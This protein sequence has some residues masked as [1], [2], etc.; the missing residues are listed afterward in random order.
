MLLRRILLLLRG[1]AA[2]ETTTVKP[3]TGRTRSAVATKASTGPGATTVAPVATVPAKDPP[4][5]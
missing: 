5:H 2:S 3:T 1:T 4:V